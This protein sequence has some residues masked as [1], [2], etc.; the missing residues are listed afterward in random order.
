LEL[1][2]Q[3]PGG[4]LGGGL[5]R[6]G[7]GPTSGK[8]PQEPRDRANALTSEI[9]KVYRDIAKIPSQDAKDWGASGRSTAPPGRPTT[10]KERL[11][12]SIPA[13]HLA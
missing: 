9:I 3:G 10:P 8:T 2:N 11:I 1:A 4:G 7:G 5:G 12:R 13:Y 6:L